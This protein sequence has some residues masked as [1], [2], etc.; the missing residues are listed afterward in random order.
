M[1]QLKIMI[2]DTET[3]DLQGN[4]YD[5]GYTVANKQGD[6]STSFNGQGLFV[7]HRRQK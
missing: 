2:L 3:C 5:V 1:N 4:V 6:I 7:A